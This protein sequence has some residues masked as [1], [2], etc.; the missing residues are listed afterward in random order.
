VKAE[1]HRLLSI[2]GFP[3]MDA[4]ADGVGVGIDVEE[5]ARWGRPAESLFTDAE[6]RHCRQFAKPAESYAGRWCAKE[7]AVKALAPFYAASVRDIEILSTLSG[8]PTARIL[9][10]TIDRWTGDLQVSIAHSPVIAIAIAI[11]IP[12]RRPR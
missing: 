6:H 5:V 2:L 11:A 4:A 10:P 12:R 8:I 9:R 3:S 7:A 1:V